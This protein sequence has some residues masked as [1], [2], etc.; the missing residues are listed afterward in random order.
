MAVNR[1]SR[2]ITMTAQGDALAGRFFVSEMYAVMDAAT[3]SGIILISDTDGE[4]IA[5][6]VTSGTDGRVDLLNNPGWYDGIVA[7]TLPA[8][9]V[10]TVITK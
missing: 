6:G 8:N 2:S 4:V 5:R 3:A 1:D 7:T 10:L 9:C